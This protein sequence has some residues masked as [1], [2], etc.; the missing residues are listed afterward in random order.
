[1]GATVS[2]A[3]TPFTITLTKK[4]GATF[5][6]TARSR[7]VTNEWIEFTNFAQSNSLANVIGRAITMS[8]TL[9]TTF[10]VAS[11]HFKGNTFTG[12]QNDP[13]SLQCEFDGVIDAGGTT[14]SITIPETCG[15][16]AVTNARVATEVQG[17]NGENTDASVDFQ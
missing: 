14:G 9:P 16:K 12:P 3:G 8:W 11:I 4:N 5:S 6:Y 13:A 10:P 7:A 17:V 2:P 15:G 1:M